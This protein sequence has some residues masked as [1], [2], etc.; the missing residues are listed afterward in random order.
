MKTFLNFLQDKHADGYMGTDD[1]MPEDFERWVSELD[2]DILID[3]ADEYA[4]KKVAP[5]L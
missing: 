1:N 3:W 5:T 4:D 2:T